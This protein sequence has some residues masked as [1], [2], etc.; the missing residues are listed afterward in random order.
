MTYP[1]TRLILIRHG[2][3]TANVAGRMQGR[4]NDPLTERGQ[5]QVEAVAQRLVEAEEPIEALYSSSL[6]RA[7]LTAKAIGVALHLD[8]RSRDALQEMHLGDLDGVTSDELTAAIP[9]D[10]DTRYPGGESPREFVE[11]IMGAFYGI[12]AAH[13]GGTV[14]VVSHGGVISTALSFWKHGHGGAWRTY[15]PNNCSLSIVEL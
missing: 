7:C 3:T 9:R 4:T 5:R 6:L 8:I 2:E 13:P 1:T 11:R 10:W 15:A 12:M 14:V